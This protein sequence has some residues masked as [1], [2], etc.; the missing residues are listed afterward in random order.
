MVDP[1][2]LSS[3]LSDYPL[4]ASTIDNLDAN[5]A[6]DR[7]I[8]FLNQS[9]D[10]SLVIDHFALVLQSGTTVIFGRSPGEG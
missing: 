1:G 3:T 4:S 7:V 5:E 10:E 6:V 2:T 8:P 9:Q